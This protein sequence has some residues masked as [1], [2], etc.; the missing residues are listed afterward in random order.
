MGNSTLL[1]K[2]FGNSEVPLVLPDQPGSVGMWNALMRPKPRYRA[3]QQPAKPVVKK[4]KA[5]EPNCP[6]SYGIITVK[7]DNP[8]KEC[9]KTFS[10]LSYRD[11]RAKTEKPYLL[12]GH[13]KPSCTNCK[14]ESEQETWALF[15]SFQS[16][17]PV[18]R[19]DSQAELLDMWLGRADR[20][21]PGVKDMLTSTP[22][23]LWQYIQGRTLWVVGDSLAQET[24]KA[25]MCFF[26][27]FWDH[28][29]YIDGPG[30][31]PVSRPARLSPPSTTT[32]G[33]ST[34]LGRLGY[35]TSAPRMFQTWSTRCYQG[36]RSGKFKKDLFLFN[37]AVH[38]NDP[39]KFKERLNNFA[40]YYT[41][42]SEDLP[43]FIWRDGSPPTL[44]DPPWG[45]HRGA[46]AGPAGVPAAAERGAERHERAGA[47][48]RGR[49]RAG[50][51]AGRLA[52]QAVHPHHA[53]A[54]HS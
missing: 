4:P 14:R 28:D 54:R 46:A 5:C 39:E 27:E 25:L 9:P 40:D 43:F 15:C 53:G 19:P 18:C 45:C 17:G 21:A 29:E 24:M 30:E 47:A 50:D 12:G 23:D 13:Q 26:T 51:P 48:E 8:G 2:R 20:G 44:Q 41:Q 35:A 22:C 10:R 38:Y 49:L 11:I 42:N 37:F 34:C 31:M 32:A 6:R 1:G 16:S 33:A 36:S 7:D 52:Q 3:P